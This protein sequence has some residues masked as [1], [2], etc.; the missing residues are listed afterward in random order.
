VPAAASEE[1]Q[2]NLELERIEAVANCKLLV[3]SFTDPI[4]WLPD[5]PDTETLHFWEVF[6]K[7]L[8][9]QEE[10]VITDSAGREAAVGLAAHDG[11]VRL[12]AIVLPS[13]RTRHSNPTVEQR[14]KRTWPYIGCRHASGRA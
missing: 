5:P 4:F 7:G 14:T 9:F 10:V 3:D 11:S 2:H 6:V 8:N 13:Q 1:E 12:A